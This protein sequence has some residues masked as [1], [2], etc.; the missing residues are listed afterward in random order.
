MATTATFD[1]G[2][3]RSSASHH[4]WQCGFALLLCAGL[5]MG[6][7]GLV[8]LGAMSL[9][10]L[11]LYFTPFGLPAWTGSALHLVQLS[12]VGA[13]VWSVTQ[14]HADSASLPWLLALSASLLVLPFVTPLLDSLALALLCTILFLLAAATAI[15]ASSESGLAG[16]LVAPVLVLVGFSAI[17]GLAVAAYAPPFALTQTHQAPP[18]A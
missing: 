13:A 10:L 12:M 18:A 8:H 16:W 4:Q 1:N 6:L 17:L 7:F 5:P 9:G 14:R 2:D 15:R 11:P 3:F